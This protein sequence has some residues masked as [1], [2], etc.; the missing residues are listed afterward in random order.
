[1]KICD[2]F[3]FKIAFVAELFEKILQMK[4]LSFSA[5]QLRISLDLESPS[6]KAE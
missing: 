5:W 4:L 6:T 2:A 3:I 1:L